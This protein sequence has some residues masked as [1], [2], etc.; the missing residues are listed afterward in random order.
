MKA[1]RITVAWLVAIVMLLSLTAVGTSATADEE[2][3]GAGITIRL[4]TRM[5]GAD[6]N[7]PIL[8]AVIK[9]FQEKYPDITIQDESVNDSDAFNSQ[10]KTDIASGNVADIIQW[11]GI[12]IMKEYAANNVFLDLSDLIAQSEDVKNNVDPSLINMM[13]LSSVGVPGVYALPIANQMEVFYYRKDLFEQAGIEQVPETWDEFE[14]DCDK[15]MAISVIPW[16]VGGSNAWRFIHIQTGLMYRNGGVQMAIDLGAGKASWTDPKVVE[17]IQFMQDLAQKGYLGTD[18]MGIDYETEK[19]R[20]VS[21]E[22]A[23]SFDGSWR[24][25]ELVKSGDEFLANVGTFRMPYFADQSELYSNDISYPSQL[26]LGGHL[27][28]EPEKLAYVWELASMFVS[29]TYQEDLLYNVSNIPVRT[30][31]VVDSNRVNSVLAEMLSFKSDVTTWGSDNWAYDTEASLET[32]VGDA[33]VGAMTGMSA[34]DAA[35]QIQDNLE[36]ARA[37]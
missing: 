1:T 8:E 2:R 23:M 31:I 16:S 10:F 34:Q 36:E 17:N 37:N 20:F 24:V 6:S 22:T 14:A 32:I 28:D 9:E 11:P 19:A 15:L 21:G 29:K 26:E 27:K 33:Y 3:T 13:E 4:L 30:D 35:Q 18:Y 25:G 5:S 7:T 12:S